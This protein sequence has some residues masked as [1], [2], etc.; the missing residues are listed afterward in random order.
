MPIC[1]LMKVIYL[2]K[3][4]VL[5]VPDIKSIFKNYILKVYLIFY[6]YSKMKENHNNTLFLGWN[7]FYLNFKREVARDF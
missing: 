2:G 1:H 4:L 7:N 5:T 3:N 6:L